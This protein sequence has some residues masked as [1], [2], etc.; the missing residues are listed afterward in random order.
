MKANEFR[1]GNL[2]LSKLGVTKIFEVGE[3]HCQVAPVWDEG[4]VLYAG[5]KDL[6]PLPINT[7]QLVR[8]GF[9]IDYHID[10]LNGEKYRD[11]SLE[12][13]GFYFVAYVDLNEYDDVSN[14]EL[15]HGS[16]DC[17]VTVRSVHELQNVYYTFFKSELTYE[18]TTELE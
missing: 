12:K 8:L 5:F 1:V 17:L 11:V 14:V 9:K 3:S 10:E 15:T 16:S 7:M 13:D 6:K 2:V 18:L 4:R